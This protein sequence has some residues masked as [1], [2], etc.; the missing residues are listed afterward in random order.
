MSQ[1][2]TQ[3]QHFLSICK[4]D[5]LDYVLNSMYRP[6]IQLLAKRKSISYILWNTKRACA[7]YEK[8]GINL[9]SVYYSRILLPGP[10][11]A[12]SLPIILSFQH[13]IAAGIPFGQFLQ[14]FSELQAFESIAQDIRRIASQTYGFV[15]KFDIPEFERSLDYIEPLPV[16]SSLINYDLTNDV[17][18]T[19]VTPTGDV[20][21]WFK[22][23]RANNSDI[24]YAVLQN[25][26]SRTPT[27]KLRRQLKSRYNIGRFTEK[28]SKLHDAFSK[29]QKKIPVLHPSINQLIQQQNCDQQLKFFFITGANVL[30]GCTRSVCIC[31]CKVFKRIEFYQIV[32]LEEAQK[33]RRALQVCRW[34]FTPQTQTYCN[35]YGH[36][37][38]NFEPQLIS[39]IK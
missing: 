26:E 31:R 14:E 23:Q 36:I 19:Y 24:K 7:Y 21:E 6:K 28:S 18:V 1:A 22:L 17:S 29:I 5:Q 12:L 16:P 3:F 38:I 37:D 32:A 39:W 4:R 8:K 10:I 15:E 34:L 25:I 13:L 33:I 35:N 20:D 2:L 9:T 11:T 30:R 27:A